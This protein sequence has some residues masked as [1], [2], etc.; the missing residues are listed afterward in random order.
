MPPA[1]RKRHLARP[2]RGTVNTYPTGMTG[3]PPEASPGGTPCRWFGY[4]LT[5]MVNVVVVFWM[6]TKLLLSTRW[7]KVTEPTAGPW[8]GSGSG[9]AQMP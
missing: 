8:P 9:L 5:V 1:V 2:P 4:G 7:L 3:V 6:L